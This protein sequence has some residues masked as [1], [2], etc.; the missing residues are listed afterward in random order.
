[1]EQKIIS[2]IIISTPLFCSTFYNFVKKV[3]KVEKIGLIKFH[4]KNKHL[5]IIRNHNL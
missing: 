2:N 4:I 1:V 3:E 5:Y